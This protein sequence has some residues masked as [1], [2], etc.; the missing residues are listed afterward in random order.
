MHTNPFIPF[1]R[2]P[3]WS[4]DGKKIA[5]LGTFPGKIHTMNASD[6]SGAIKI[7]DHPA[8][9]LAWQPNTAPVID[10]LAP[11]PG[12]ETLDKTP[13]IRATVYDTQTNLAKGD[14]TLLVDGLVIPKAEFSYNRKTDRL[15]FTPDTN[16]SIGDHA[17]KIVA[18]DDALLTKSRT[19]Q[20]QVKGAVIGTG[21]P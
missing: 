6:E 21:S 20:F 9:D 2:E 13:T 7:S 16:L 8:H 10:D 11:S 18:R 14:M 5:F 12:S 15:S 17:A 1:A 4:P 3:V 19:W